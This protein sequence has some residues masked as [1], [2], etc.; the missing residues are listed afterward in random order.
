MFNVDHKKVT[1]TVTS[2]SGTTDQGC[3]AES[4][5]PGHRSPQIGDYVQVARARARARTRCL[6]TQSSQRSRRSSGRPR[7]VVGQA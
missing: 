4:A 1:G 2:L 3:P 6:V 5:V 7:W